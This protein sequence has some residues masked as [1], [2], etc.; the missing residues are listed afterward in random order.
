MRFLMSAGVLAVL[1]STGCHGFPYPEPITQAEH[2]PEKYPSYTASS[3]APIAVGDQ[4]WL[5]LPGGFAGV[6]STSLL[7]V[8]TRALF[9]S[10]PWDTP[11]YDQLYG[12]GADGLL[13]VAEEVR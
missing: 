6:A 10:A 9:F 13:H 8:G 3:A 2:K 4:R 5:L 7:P 11:P 12:Q 1:I